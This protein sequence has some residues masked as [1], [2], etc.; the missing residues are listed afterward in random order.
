MN[1]LVIGESTYCLKN[2]MNQYPIENMK[3]DITEKYESGGGSAANIAYLL[4]SWGLETYLATVIGN[5]D[6]AN[7]IKKELQ[8]VRV[9]TDYI[10]TNFEKKTPMEFI[11]INKANGSRTD[12]TLLSDVG[13][14][15]KEEW[16]TN[17]DFIISDGQEYHATIQAF[18]KFPNS[19]SVLLADSLT[20]EKV[21]LCKYSK[22]I[23]FSKDFA[24]QNTRLK[25]N[26]SKPNDLVL[27]YNSLVGK[28]PKAKIIVT[29]GEDGAL[30]SVNNNIRIMPGLKAN[31]K[32]SSGAGDIFVGSF[33]Y[34]LSCNY[35]LEKCITIANISAGLST[36]LIG[37]RASIPVLND[38]LTYYAQKYSNT[39]Q[40]NNNN[41]NNVSQPQNQTN[42]INN[43]PVQTTNLNQNIETPK[44]NVPINAN[45]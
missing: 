20:P 15:K 22:Y 5:D 16:N 34:S 3:Y 29:L 4:G 39:P 30:Y 26:S 6:Y 18:T 25:I 10:E 11:L 32:D 45:K 40:T 24:E 19:N 35:D 2:I 31:V 9:K 38:V 37:S 36:E 23:I 21:D 33:V 14:L 17:P 27:L 8:S 43:S 12:F 41:S 13:H 7:I 28:Y 44:V 1:V 42:S